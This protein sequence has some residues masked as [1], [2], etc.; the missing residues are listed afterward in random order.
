MKLSRLFG[1][2]WIQRDVGATGFEDSQQPYDHF[3]GAIQVDGDEHVGAD[4]EL[5]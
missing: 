2:A 4:T 3:Y 5:L 1:I